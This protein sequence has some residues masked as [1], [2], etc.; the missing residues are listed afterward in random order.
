MCVDTSFRKT[1]STVERLGLLAVPVLA[2]ALLSTGCSVGGFAMTKPAAA[3]TETAINAEET[4]VE[5][6]A[7]PVAVEKT[8]VSSDAMQR[9]NFSKTAMAQSSWEIAEEGLLTLVEDY[10]ELS[11]P[12]LNLALVYRHAQDNR[13]AEHWFKQSIARNRN[14]LLAYNQYGIF[15]REQGRFEQAE[16][17]YQQALSISEVDADTH[18]NLG[19]LYDLYRGDKGAALA[20]FIRY[21]ELQDSDDR[22][23][24]GWIA[25]L[26][27]QLN[28]VALAE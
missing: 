4:G 19:I 6:S 11:G 18:L 22:V 26:E 16:E 21:Q 12:S 8:A 2:A 25:D 13:Q 14:N 1:V 23:V 7:N 15:L 5:N 9:F 27:R 10:P 17:T 24:A 28:S 20:H 3:V